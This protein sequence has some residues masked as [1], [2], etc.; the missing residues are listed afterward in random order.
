MK[1]SDIIAAE[2]LRLRT[3]MHEAGHAVMAVLAGA[4]I[5]ECKVSGD[6]GHVTCFDPDP[7]RVAGIGWA[8]PFAEALF[9]YGDHPPE[10]ALR[11]LRA[12]ASPEDRE[13][14]S[15]GRYRSV[16]G[17]VRFAMPAI[18]RLAF[19]LHRYG[20]ANRAEIERAVGV[21]PGLD[22]A[23]VRWAYRQRIDPTTITPAGSAA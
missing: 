2:R 11:T 7:E 19:H 23:M 13:A 17:D 5:D 6:K 22:I 16:E 15:R 20:N 12:D 4:E 9:T 14:M 3:A 1:M 18:R 21:R 10:D 8:G